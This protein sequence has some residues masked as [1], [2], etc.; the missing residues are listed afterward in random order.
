[1]VNK[2]KCPFLKQNELLKFVLVISEISI[3]VGCIKSIWSKTKTKI[4]FEN[5][6]T[7]VN[8]KSMWIPHLS[9]QDKEML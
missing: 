9:L 5:P 4:S 3:T 6:G 1:M 2:L 7:N 8:N